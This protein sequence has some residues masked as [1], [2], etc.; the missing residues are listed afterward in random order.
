[1]GL[2]NSFLKNN[3]VLGVILG[4]ILFNIYNIITCYMPDIMS[5]VFDLILNIFLVYFLVPKWRNK[6][7]HSS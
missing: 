2:I 3:K 7:Q 6:K 5:V 1:M 4:L